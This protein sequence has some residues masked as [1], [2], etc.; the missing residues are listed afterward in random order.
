[1]ATRSTLTSGDSWQKIIFIP[2]TACC[3]H[4]LARMLALAGV[5]ATY[6]L[7]S[8]FMCKRVN[9]RLVSLTITT[10]GMEVMVVPYMEVM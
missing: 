6:G 9:C 2:H 8:I 5:H 7:V 3:V 1:M 10:V 4:G